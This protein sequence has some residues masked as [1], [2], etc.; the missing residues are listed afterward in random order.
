LTFRN[1]VT[2][3]WGQLGPVLE[4]MLASGPQR[5]FTTLK[6]FY[7]AY[8]KQARRNVYSI[9]IKREEKQLKILL[10]NTRIHTYNKVKR[11][12]SITDASDDSMA[13]DTD[14]DAETEHEVIPV[15][16]DELTQTVNN[17]LKTQREAVFILQ[18]QRDPVPVPTTR[19]VYLR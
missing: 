1:N 16:K 5:E 2:S 7:I 17:W 9:Y 12:F 14:S 18:T 15:T 4:S 8:G 3:F 19:S 6:E 11:I 13:V 10:E